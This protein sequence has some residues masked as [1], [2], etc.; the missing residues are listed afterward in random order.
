MT[1]SHT[2][3]PV[4]LAQKLALFTE[5]WQPRIVAEMNDYQFKVLKVEGDFV[6]HSHAD[7]DETFIILEGELRIDFRDSQVHLA[8]G[9]MIVVPKG[10]EHK[11]YAEREVKILLVEPRGV[12]NTGEEGG[13]LTAS[14]DVWV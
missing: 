11:P 10:V 1:A 9:E 12:V 2:P 3:S 6:W 5:H 13:D 14:N 4:N 7:T 8:A